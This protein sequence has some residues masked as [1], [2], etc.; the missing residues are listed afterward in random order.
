MTTVHR[1]TTLTRHIEDGLGDLIHFR[2]LGQEAGDSAAGMHVVM[3][4]ADWEEMGRPDTL[5]VALSTPEHV[6]VTEGGITAFPEPTATLDQPK[7]PPDQPAFDHAAAN[8]SV[9]FSPLTQPEGS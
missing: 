5:H 4:P 9:A 1:T 6:P 3:H 2:H 7:T 8:E